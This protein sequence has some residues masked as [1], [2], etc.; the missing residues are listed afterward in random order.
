MA[1]LGRLWSDGMLASGSTDGSLSGVK[2]CEVLK[3]LIEPERNILGSLPYG[4]RSVLAALSERGE[5]HPDRKYTMVDLFEILWK[6]FQTLVASCLDGD[7]K[8]GP[9]HER[10]LDIFHEEM[11][12]TRIRCPSEVMPVEDWVIEFQCL[13]KAFTGM[14][15]DQNVVESLVERI[16]PTSMPPTRGVMR[17]LLR[18]SVA[19]RICG[20][21]LGAEAG[22]RA[23]RMSRNCSC[24]ALRRRTS[25]A[26]SARTWRRRS[27]NWPGRRRHLAKGTSRTSALHAS[28]PEL[29]RRAFGCW[30]R[31]RRRFGLPWRTGWL[32]RGCPRP[33]RTPRRS[34]QS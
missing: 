3:S 16:V 7:P 9:L 4:R 20:R 11:L 26:V 18:A 33:S 15:P 6:P 21:T 27:A 2:F 22:R 17:L 34:S 5:G 30:R 10:L 29:S 32:T 23:R 31:K 19:E 1:L 28:D 24:R 25:A 13:L 8:V 14:E 12:G